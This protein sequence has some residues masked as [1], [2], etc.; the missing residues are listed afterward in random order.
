MVSTSGD[1]EELI[2]K[3]VGNLVLPLANHAV[4]VRSLFISPY[5]NAESS[6]FTKVL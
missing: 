2:P 1:D 4:Q 6:A 5:N 3:L